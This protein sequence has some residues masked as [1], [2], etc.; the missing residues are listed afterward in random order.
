M[1]IGDVDKDGDLDILWLNGDTMDNFVVKPN[2]GLHLLENHKGKLTRKFLG[3]FPGIHKAK[4][5]DVDNDGDLDI[6][7]V[8]ALFPFGIKPENIMSVGLFEKFNLC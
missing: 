5:G 6:V 3:F 4:I 2:Q 7:G 8:S 1:T